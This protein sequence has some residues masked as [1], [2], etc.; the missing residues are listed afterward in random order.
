MAWTVT[1]TIP[2]YVTKSPVGSQLINLY[3]T[4]TLFRVQCPNGWVLLIDVLNARK[5]PDPRAMPNMSFLNIGK[6]PDIRVQALVFTQVLA[7]YS[8]LNS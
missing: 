6:D 1:T 8:L 7:S 2:R 5:E 4:H 3:K